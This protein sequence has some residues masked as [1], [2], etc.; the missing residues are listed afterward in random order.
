M[1]T[2]TDSLASSSARALPVRARPDLSAKQQRYLGQMYWVLKEPVGLKYFRFQEEEFAILKMLDGRTSLDEIKVEFERRFPPQKITVEE[3]GHFV[4]MLHK[5]GLVI[6]SV[7]GQGEQLCKRRW[8]KKLQEVASTFSNV[9][10]LRFKGVDPERLLNWLYPKVRWF[11]SVPALVACGL[12][13]LSALLLVTV[14]FESFHNKLPTFH[15]FFEAKNW[16]YLGATLAV[17]KVIHEFGHGLSCKHFGGECH[18]IGVMFLVLTPCLYC[19]VSDSW[20]LPNKWHRAAIGAAGMYVEIVIASIC[21]YLWWFSQPG[22]LN[23]LCLSTMFVCSVST[24]LFNGNPLLRYDGY[25]ILS[26]LTEIPNLRQKSSSILSRKLGKWCLGLEEPD[27]P[28]LPQRNQVFFALYTVASS[29]YKWM[30]LF[31]ILFFLYKVF[32]PY[33]LKVL[34]QTLALVSLTSLVAMPV[35]K[36]AKFFYVPGRLHK[37]K[38]KN[39]NVTLGILAV[40]ALFILFCPL[41]YRVVCPLELRLR[42]A[43][44]VYVQVPGILEE[45]AVS[46]GDE[47]KKGDKLGQLSNI[48][49][50]LEI[51]DLEAKIAQDKVRRAVLSHQQFALG[52]ESATLAIGPLEESLKASEAQLAERVTDSQRLELVAPTSGTVMPAPG[53]PERPDADDRQLRTWSGNPLQKENRGA[54]LEP[55]T[56]YC[57]I[58]DPHK[59]EANIVIDQDD[60]EFVHQGQTVKIKLDRLPYRTFETT[61]LEIGPEMEFSSRQISSKGG[62]GLMSKMDKSGRERPINTSFQGRAEIDDESGTLVQGLRGNAKIAAKWQPI[63]KRVWRYIMR[64]FN[65]RL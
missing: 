56:V 40:V 54:Y 37:V 17:T 59:W 19:N 29:L 42:G 39:V 26:D 44:P 33:G 61:I 8:E 52:N 10:A 46:P 4:G 62:G 1:V 32:E 21:T 22:M 12:L 43:E 7:S 20:M 3:L 23:Q 11:F 24:V 2:L 35:Y 15:Q 9:L 27:D 65:F 30:I 51:S 45:I 28:F 63:G 13:A 16:I 48:D 60:I 5:S 41:P 18:E 6:A 47:V 64:T 38:R 34:S 31:G 49:L 57:Q 25:Y 50:E 36:V 55:P 14:E 53:L 58:G